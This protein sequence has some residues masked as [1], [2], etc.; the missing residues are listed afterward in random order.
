M[1]LVFVL[2]VQKSHHSVGSDESIT[3]HPMEL[4]PAQ[5]F[6]CGLA[7]R[8]VEVDVEDEGSRFGTGEQGTE[9]RQSTRVDI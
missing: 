9:K 3:A 5:I 4:R 8:A 7:S 1:W 6:N 2:V